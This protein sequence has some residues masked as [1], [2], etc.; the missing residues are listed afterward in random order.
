MGL[1]REGGVGS[2]QQGHKKVQLAWD[3][4]WLKP[5]DKYFLQDLKPVATSKTKIPRGQYIINNL[6]MQPRV[7]V[8]KG[9]REAYPKTQNPNSHINLTIAV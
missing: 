3:K 7:I 8:S 2:V 1:A 5:A 6:K 4:Y 9:A